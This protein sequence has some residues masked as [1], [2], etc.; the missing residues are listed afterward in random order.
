MAPSQLWTT[1]KGDIG[2][3]GTSRSP[4]LQKPYFRSM[5]KLG[6]ILSSPVA[7]EN[8]AFISTITGRTYCIGITGSVV[9]WHANT[10]APIVSTPSIYDR[11]LIVATF[12]DWIKTATNKHD[13]SKIVAFNRRD[14]AEVWQFELRRG[15]FSSICS[16]RDTHVVGCLDGKIYALTTEGNLRWHFVTR[17]EVWCSPSSD[18]LRIIVGSDDGILYA[19]DMDGS[20][21]WKT[22]LQGKVR[23]SS[24]CLCG[25]E[26]QE[27]DNDNQQGHDSDEGS[28][29]IGTQQGILYRIDKRNGAIH[30]AVDLGSPVLSSPS[31]FQ[32]RIVVGTTDGYLHCMR[33]IDGSHIWKFRTSG[34]IWSSPILTEEGMKIFV[35]SLDSHIYCL[36]ANSGRLV[37]KFPTMGWIDSSPSIAHGLLLVGSRDGFLYVFDRGENLPY[38]R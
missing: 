26:H 4:F 34:K 25:Q 20:L 3:A 18:G 2:R 14:G 35:G 1:F 15:I 19:L 12:S 11:F 38:I 33:S 22:Q 30:W 36:D 16:L 13:P 37:W 28:L 29:C 6:P 31:S 24:P 7:D 8:S 17:G 10:S 5:L 23:T 9:S 32:N 21:I 27:R